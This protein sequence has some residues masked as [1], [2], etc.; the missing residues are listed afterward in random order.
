MNHIPKNEK[1]WVIIRKRGKDNYHVITSKEDNRSKYY[2]YNCHN[3]MADR[4]GNSKS[5]SE[6]EEKWPL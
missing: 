1:I 2:I 5:P 3:G 4:L 6:L